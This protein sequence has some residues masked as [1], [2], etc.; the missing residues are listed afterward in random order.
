M[1]FNGSLDFSGSDFDQQ[2][3][4][5]PIEQINTSKGP[6]TVLWDSGSMLNL[7]STEWADKVGLVG[8]NVILI[9][10]LLIIL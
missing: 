7:I 4:K 10:K 5:L 2:V 6:C 9:T 1:K 8:K 3:V